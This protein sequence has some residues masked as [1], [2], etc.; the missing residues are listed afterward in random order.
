MEYAAIG[1]MAV[2]GVESME[3]LDRTYPTVRTSGKAIRLGRLIDVESGR[4]IILPLSHSLFL[5]P[6][7]GWENAGSIRRAIREAAGGGASAF[8]MSPGMLSICA[9]EFVGRGAPGLV[10]QLDWTN[11]WRD[12]GRQLGYPEGRNTAIAT[13]EQAA[14]MG[15][16][17]IMTY[18]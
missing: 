16:D 9:D 6:D 7:V 8:V 11:M 14:H 3:R 13:V 18:L 5:G 1:R 12:E 17:A 4:G 10:I 15:A 2:S